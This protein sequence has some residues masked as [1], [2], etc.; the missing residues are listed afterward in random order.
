MSPEGGPPAPVTVG[1][2]VGGTKVLGVAL[3]GR[4]R[5]V[6]EIRLATPLHRGG[7]RRRVIPGPHGD[8]TSTANVVAGPEPRNSGDLE[9][10]SESESDDAV[11]AG[12]LPMG[13]STGHQSVEAGEVMAVVAEAVVELCGR[14]SAA[15]AE[16]AGVG[17]GLPG[18][19]GP[20]GS[21]RFAPNLVQGE[22][23]VVGAELSSLVGRLPVA[24]D[25][26]A[27][28]AALSEWMVGAARG[29]Q[30]ALVVTFGTGIGSGIV[31]GGTLA[32][33]ANGA[34]GEAGH[35]VIDP[36]GPVCVCGQRGCWERFAS[37][38]GLGRLTR[39]AAQAGRLSDLVARV[40]GDP[41]RVRGEHVSAAAAAGDAA[42]HAVLAELAQWLALGL[43]NLANLLDPSVIVLGGGLMES[44]PTLLDLAREAFHDR[45]ER[46]DGRP[47]VRIVAAALG[48]RAGAVG[49]AMLARSGHRHG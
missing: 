30:D 28:C 7:T 40:G 41:E 25:N 35:M 43:A 22:G 45:V 32:R 48:D 46:R 38:S 26:D 12:P 21:L 11:D 29:A 15:G 14:V 37:G 17:V 31:V 44:G 9:S 42:A 19:I 23:L 20:D 36:H 24:I 13:V 3:D 39:E 1:V 10:E 6:T 5:L 2:D 4:D 16:V 18:Q 27:N 49:A 8:V 33:G 34:A 47:E